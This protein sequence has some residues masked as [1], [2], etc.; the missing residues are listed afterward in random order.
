MALD[1]RR[2]RRLIHL[3]LQPWA[4]EQLEAGSRSAEPAHQ[5]QGIT[6]LRPAPRDEAA[7]IRCMADDRNR[8]KED[9]RCDDIAAHH[10]NFLGGGDPGH[11]VRERKQ[12]GFGEILGE[13][14]LD[15]GLARLCA[16][17]RQVGER[18]R[19]GFVPDRLGR[20]RGAPEVNA[21]D[22]RIDRGRCGAPRT[23]HS[24]IVAA[25]KR[26]PFRARRACTGDPFSHEAD[27]LEFAWHPPGRIGAMRWIVLAGSVLFAYLALFPGGLVLSTID[28]ACAGPDCDQPLAEDILLGLLYFVCFT[29][30]CACS[31]AMAAYF[32]RTTVRGELWIR[33]TLVAALVAVGVTLLAQ[34]ALVFPFAAL[35]TLAIGGVVYGTLRMLYGPPADEP[36]VP[37]HT[38]NGHGGL[39]GRRG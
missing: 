24:G 8:Q 12:V 36:E 37:D 15:Q 35:F 17:G 19:Q 23:A 30:V 26:D 6:R 18:N 38:Q 29:C 27:E 32:F 11:A 9:G 34:F 2:G 10:G 28:S 22:D 39:N 3:A 33:R 20:V 13:A 7:G 25:G 14:E 4:F 1:Q 5:N 31:A 21:F 16:H